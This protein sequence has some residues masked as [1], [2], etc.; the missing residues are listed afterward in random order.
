MKPLNSLLSKCICQNWS[1]GREGTLEMWDLNYIVLKM[2]IMYKCDYLCLRAIQGQQQGWKQE[3]NLLASQRI[4][5]VTLLI[6]P[7]PL[8]FLQEERKLWHSYQ[9]WWELRSRQISIFSDLWNT[10]HELT[11]FSQEKFFL[12][13]QKFNGNAFSSFKMVSYI[14]QVFLPTFSTMLEGFPVYSSRAREADRT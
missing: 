5:N 1:K 4:L 3:H 13:T 9:F 12:R 2:I 14:N 10:I 8:Y 11:T 7:H 6:I